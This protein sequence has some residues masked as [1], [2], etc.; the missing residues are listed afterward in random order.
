MNNA[1]IKITYKWKGKEVSLSCSQW[2]KLTGTAEA[3]IRNRLLRSQRGSHNYTKGQILGI[4]DMPFAKSVNN[5][6]PMVHKS[7]QKLYDLC[8]HMLG[9]RLL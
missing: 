7:E 3:T 5:T 8:R 6:V 4:T 1:K 9:K 2:S